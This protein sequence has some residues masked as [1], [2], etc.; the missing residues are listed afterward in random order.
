MAHTNSRAGLPLN[1]QKEQGAPI[2]FAVFGFFGTFVLCLAFMVHCAAFGSR[3]NDSKSNFIVRFY[4][5]TLNLEVTITLTIE[6]I[7]R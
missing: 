6:E 2:H 7:F 5:F 4:I 3:F 1:N